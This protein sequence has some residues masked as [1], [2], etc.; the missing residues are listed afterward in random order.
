MRWPIPDVC[1]IVL[2]LYMTLN[3]FIKAPI[4]LL[5]GCMLILWATKYTYLF[6]YLGFNNN[7][8][9]YTNVSQ[10]IKYIDIGKGLSAQKL[11][12]IGL[13][14]R[15]KS[16]PMILSIIYIYISLNSEICNSSSSVL[17]LCWKKTNTSWDRF[18]DN[19]LSTWVS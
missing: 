17:W 16:V 5:T 3:P 13:P 4:I 14:V 18:C 1:C 15:A 7:R 10:H 8:Y 11:I 12:M 19:L 6:I 9:I 2:L